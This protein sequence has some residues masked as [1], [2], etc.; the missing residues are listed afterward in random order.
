LKNIRGRFRSINA[1]K[2]NETNK[3]DLKAHLEKIEQDLKTIKEHY[4]TLEPLVAAAG[5]SLKSLPMIFERMKPIIEA[6]QKLCEREEA[7]LP[8]TVA[9]PP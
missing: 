2:K 7:A 3:D 5:D 8:K 4:A 6:H 9:P 1:L